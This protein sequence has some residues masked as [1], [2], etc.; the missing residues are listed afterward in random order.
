MK[1]S[2]EEKIL[3]VT[4]GN[5]LKFKNPVKN[6]CKKASQKIWTLPHLTNYLDDS[7]INVIIKPQFSCCPLVWMFCFRQTNNMINKLHERA[8]R[9]VLK[10]RVSDFQALLR[11]SNNISC[12]RRNIQMF[13][14]ELYKIKNEFAPLILNS[15]LNKKN[16]TYNFRN[17][18]EFQS[19]RKRNVFNGL[20]TLSY[21]APQLW[22]LL[23]KEK[24]HN[25]SL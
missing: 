23:P 25:K 5:K 13:M 4:I 9:R 8:L 24:R 19:E 2:S 20:E 6:L 17:L 16:I 10:D 11:K 3:R 1:K 7:E 18:E 21:R 12:H 22:T 14:I 15:M